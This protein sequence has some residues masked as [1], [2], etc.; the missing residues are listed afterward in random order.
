MY[1]LRKINISNWPDPDNPLELSKIN[2]D[3]ITT[4]LKT[5][6]NLISWFLIDE[7]NDDN[8]N[9]IAAGIGSVFKTKSRVCLV[10]I[11]YNEIETVA[12]SIEST[13]I[14]VSKYAIKL[15]GDRHHNIRID[16]YGTL[17]ELAKLV[18]KA[19]VNNIENVR[20]YSFDN[21][22]DIVK[23][24]NEKTLVN[25]DNLGLAIKACI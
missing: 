20:T 17:G 22:V 23:D 16:D 5:Q 14:K 13:P 21:I 6:Q 25:L 1:L 3:A 18:S 7:L 8:F 24:L 4:D 12:Q 19:T 11:P 2:S 15:A 10:A 9:L